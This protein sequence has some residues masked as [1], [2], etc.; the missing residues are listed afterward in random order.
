MREPDVVKSRETMVTRRGGR[1]ESRPEYHRHIVTEKPLTEPLPQFG[2]Y[3]KTQTFGQ[4][5]TQKARSDN[6]KYIKEPSNKQKYEHGY[7]DIIDKNRQLD[8]D[9]QRLSSINKDLGYSIMQ[10]PQHRKERVKELSN[11]VDLLVSYNNELN[12]TLKALKDEMDYVAHGGCRKRARPDIKPE[13]KQ[14]TENNVMFLE[15]KINDKENRIKELLSEMKRLNSNTISLADYRKLQKQHEECS[16]TIAKLENELKKCKEGIDLQEVSEKNKDTMDNKYELLLEEKNKKLHSLLED[17]DRLNEENLRLKN[18]VEN[19]KNLHSFN[20]QL[21]KDIP[22]ATDEMI[23]D[24]RYFSDRN[25]IP[26]DRNSM[27]NTNKDSTMHRQTFNKEF[28]TNVAPRYIQQ[29]M[30]R[31]ERTNT[32]FYSPS[33]SRKKPRTPNSDGSPSNTNQNNIES[34]QMNKESRLI[35]NTDI[36]NE[37]SSNKDDRVLIEE[38]EYCDLRYRRYQSPAVSSRSSHGYL[39]QQRNRTIEDNKQLSNQS[40][41]TPKIPVTYY[42]R[43]VALTKPQK[44]TPESDKQRDDYSIEKYSEQEPPFKRYVI[45]TTSKDLTEPVSTYNQDLNLNSLSPM[46]PTDYNTKRRSDRG[47]NQG[48][49]FKFHEINETEY[50]SN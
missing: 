6:S 25:I 7:I 50:R 39:L 32:S 46:T 41:V 13:N 15:Q 38:G 17:N 26:E 18:E 10:Q 49:I 27:R 5:S 23:D 30:R 12:R 21:T 45:S 11:K 1:R 20:I 44:A 14:G 43:N 22:T 8:S 31:K 9:L 34:K 29:A 36:N 4:T 2:D 40:N 37:Y 3:R 35:V 28:L 33:Q 48:N 47:N 24:Y 42:M 16:K 19:L